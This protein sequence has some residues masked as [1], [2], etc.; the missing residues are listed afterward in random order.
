VRPPFASNSWIRLFLGAFLL[1]C[2]LSGARADVS[3]PERVL[4]EPDADLLRRCVD[5]LSHA[6]SLEVVI[7][8]STWLD[9]T[10]PLLGPHLEAIVAT[11]P[12]DWGESLA[13]KH[14]R[15]HRWTETRVPKAGS[16]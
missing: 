8:N 9:A 10:E 3:S 14:F 7:P 4:S 12:P 16:R 13:I 2:P 1:N 5:R 6:A 15:F 11:P